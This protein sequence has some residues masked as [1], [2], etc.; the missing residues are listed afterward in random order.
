MKPNTNIFYYFE[1]G[2]REKKKIEHILQRL[3][4]NYVPIK[5]PT[6]KIDEKFV[7]LMLEFCNNGFDDIVKNPSKVDFGIEINDLKCSELVSLIVAEPKKFLKQAW[8]LGISGSEGVVTSKAIED[9]FTIYL[10]YEKR[11]MAKIYG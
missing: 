9:E 5:I 2:D 4:I 10:K 6:S 3:G 7:W 11:E 8:F 1:D